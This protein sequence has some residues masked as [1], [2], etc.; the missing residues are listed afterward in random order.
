M[1]FIKNLFEVNDLIIK[2]ANLIK[3]EKSLI[4]LI[5]LIIVFK[6]RKISLNYEFSFEKIF[7]D[8]SCVL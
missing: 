8:T 6:V 7:C 1:S 5:S 2:A 3:H 4:I